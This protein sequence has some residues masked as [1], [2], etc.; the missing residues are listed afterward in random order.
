MS[1]GIDY[2]WFRPS[3]AQLL[4]YDFV[5]RYLS[6]DPSKNLTL[7][8]AKQL[9]AWG[10][11]IICNWESDGKG[12]TFADG[13]AQARAAFTLAAQCGMP[14]G[15]GIVFSIDEDVD[16][17]TQ[18]GYIQG[19]LSVQPGSV[20]GLYG[21]AATVQ[22]GRAQSLA[23]GWRSMSTGW[24]GGSSTSGCQLVQ[25]GGNNDFDY[26]T[27]L[28]DLS[29]LAWNLGA[30]SAPP[31]PTPPAP[32]T[33]GSYQQNATHNLETPIPQDGSFGP[34]SWR[35]LQYVM[36]GDDPAQLDGIP[37]HN[38]VSH[39]QVM[40]DNWRGNKLFVDGVLTKYGPTIK[41]FQE[42]VGTTQDGDWGPA[43]SLAAQKRL[44][45]GVLWGGN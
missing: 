41:A 7:A 34:A 11:K 9:T 24:R 25:T 15:H 44:N 17:L 16:P 43:T 10:K 23:W 4:G 21:S 40:L 3:A 39:L 35:A 42:K 18:A 14:D 26:D 22:Y 32:S 8:E 31:T 36:F 20:L 19:L 2:A 29:G 12:G 1:Q 27:A 45:E 38:T 13:Q 37:G 5:S 33:A 6:Y 30:A 28:S